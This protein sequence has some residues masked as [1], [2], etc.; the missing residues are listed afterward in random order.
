MQVASGAGTSGRGPR[1]SFEQEGEHAL[2]GP[3]RALTRVVPDEAGAG[4]AHRGVRGFAI[5]VRV[6]EQHD[7][8]HPVGRG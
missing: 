7:A 4:R 3:A 5:R 6:E 1:R 8:A 2:A